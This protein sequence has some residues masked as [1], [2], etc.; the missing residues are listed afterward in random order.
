MW[1]TSCLKLILDEKQ[2]LLREQFC[3]CLLHL[4]RWHPL[5]E[6]V[7]E[8]FE[9]IGSEGWTDGLQPLPPQQ[10]DDDVG[11]SG[12]GGDVP[13]EQQLPTAEGQSP[14]ELVPGGICL[15]DCL[16]ATVNYLEDHLEDRG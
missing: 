4:L 9:V 11:Q 15:R 14:A 3:W 12:R 1:T 16:A 6:V 10:L 8:S 7:E 5:Q 2:K 13:G